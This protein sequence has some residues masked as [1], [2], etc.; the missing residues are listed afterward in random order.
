MPKKHLW[1]IPSWFDIGSCS[2]VFYYSLT[3]QDLSFHPTLS[4]PSA[5]TIITSCGFRITP[6]WPP[7]HLDLYTSLRPLFLS[8]VCSFSL[9]CQATASHSS[10][11]GW[12][13]LDCPCLLIFLSVSH[14]PSPHLSTLFLS[15]AR[16]LYHASLPCRA[17]IGWRHGCRGVRPELALLHSSNS[18]CMSVAGMTCVCVCVC[19]CVCLGGFLLKEYGV[20]WP[21]TED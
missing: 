3:F 11:I 19:V 12:W 2:W 16:W 7:L 5:G 17:I 20:L 4:P 10:I 6:C 21:I 18:V 14:H 1:K 15:V 8:P 9:G 13:L